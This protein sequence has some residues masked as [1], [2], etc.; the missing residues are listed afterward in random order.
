LIKKY[1]EKT[2]DNFSWK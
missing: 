2:V 1:L